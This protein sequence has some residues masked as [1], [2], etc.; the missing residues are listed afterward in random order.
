MPSPTLRS[1]DCQFSVKL[2]SCIICTGARIGDGA[3]LTKCEVGAKTEVS[4]KTVSKGQ[5]LIGLT[6]GSDDE[7]D[8]A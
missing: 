7:A 3:Q 4:A 1:T 5:Q 6:G 2:E 8:F